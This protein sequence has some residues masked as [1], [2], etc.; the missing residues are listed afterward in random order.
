MFSPTFKHCC[1]DHCEFEDIA[2][3]GKLKNLEILSFLWSNIAQLPSELGQ[4]TKLRLLDLSDCYNL[5]VIAPRVISSLIRLE[6]LYMSN[7]SVEW[8]N[9]GSNGESS[10]PSLNELMH[11][12]YLSALEIDIE[13]ENVLTRRLALQKAGKKTSRI[14][15]LKFNSTS[16]R[17]ENLQGVKDVEY[18]Y[19]DKLQGVKNVV[20]E[21]DT[22]GFTQ[23]KHLHVQNNPEFLCIVDSM[24]RVSCDAFPLL[25]S[26]TLH[27]LINLEKIC[28]DELRAKS[29][30][31]LNIIK[32]AMIDCENMEE[33]FAIGGE[34][35]ANNNQVH[36]KIEFAQLTSL[37]LRSLPQLTCFCKVITTQENLITRSSSQLFSEKVLLPNLEA[38]ELYEINVEKIWHNQLPILSSYAFEA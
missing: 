20:F 11:L 23:L 32:I 33:I 38:L 37:S 9:E 22:E 12:P 25:E 28:R 8:E 2:I 21:L 6:E 1:L 13:N 27:Y 17:S 30:H 36:D 3:I 16:I 10:N 15:K 29:F 4:L 7:C 24:E 35:D 34:N 18:L 31:E 26:L 19:L 14:L 5:K